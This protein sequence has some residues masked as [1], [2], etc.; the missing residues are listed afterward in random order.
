M[1]RQG[2][3]AEV[4]SRMSRILRGGFSIQKLPVEVNRAREITDEQKH[5]R[6]AAHHLFLQQGGPS[7]VVWRP[8][9][10]GVATGHRIACEL[11]DS[12]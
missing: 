7:S 6:Q 2:D 4:E 9:L 1:D 10:S 8:S 11:V 5:L 3:L 12:N